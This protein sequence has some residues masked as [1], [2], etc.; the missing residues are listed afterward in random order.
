LSRWL[1][2]SMVC[3]GRVPVRSNSGSLCKAAAFIGARIF[4]GN[5]GQYSTDSS[6]VYELVELSGQFDEFVLHCFVIEGEQARDKLRLPPSARLVD[7]GQIL[8][9]W[10]LY[11]H[12]LRLWRRVRDSVRQA[13]WSYAVLVE[14]RLTSLFAL[15]ACGLARR[16]AIAFIRG[17]PTTG[18]MAYRYGQGPRVVVGASL[19]WFGIL[20]QWILAST[21]AVVT[22]S[23]VVRARLSQR[24]AAVHHVAAAS[25]SEAEVLA[26]GEPWSGPGHGPMRLLFVGRLERIKDVEMLLEAVH[27]AS[28]TGREYSLQLV[29]SGDR[30]Y[31]ALLCSRVRNLGLDDRVEFV[32]AVPHGF[33]LFE[34]YQKAHALVLSSRSE[35]IPKVVIEAMAHGLPVIATSVGGLP[36]LVRPEIGILVAPVDAAE[37]TQA[38][39][40]IY[41]SPT[42]AHTMSRAARQASL[43]LLAGPVSR[44]LALLTITEARPPRVNLAAFL[45]RGSKG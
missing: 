28:T 2:W 13:D 42:L 31:T 4:V 24:G 40:T 25:I 10:D 21:V 26:A 32:G 34:C 5:D 3:T 14:P 22:D 45:R 36:G 29:G 9:G 41:D 33:Q 17:D 7:L 11:G 23:D 44:E 30:D 8:R 43:A 6:L 18:P 12:P 27:A 19:R 37:L 1:A 15:V 16:S 35:G 38:L 20:V 39:I